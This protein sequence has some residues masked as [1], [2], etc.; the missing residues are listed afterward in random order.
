MSFKIY[1]RTNTK[2]T[3]GAHTPCAM[4]L[5]LTRRGF[6]QLSKAAVQ[7]LGIA[8]GDGV[9]LL[10]DEQF[11][12]FYIG[13]GDANRG[14]FCLTKVGS[15]ARLG[16]ACSDIAEIL[17]KAAIAAPDWRWMVCT[18]FPAPEGKLGIDLKHA[19]FP[20]RYSGDTAAAVAAIKAK[21]AAKA[22]QVAETTPATKKR[23]RPAKK[24]QE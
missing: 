18:L 15:S 16:F 19:K 22:A 2:H 23:G 7:F 21:N 24:G 5:S 6:I 11:N 17:G 8:S 3:F 14:A 9:V 20:H 12:D 4:T 13:R 10:E 1:N